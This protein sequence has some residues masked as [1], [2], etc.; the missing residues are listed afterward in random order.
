MTDL[1]NAVALHQRGQLNEAERIYRDILGADPNHLM[2]PIFLA[3]FFFFNVAKPL[4]G[5]S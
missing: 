4:R 5:S 2:R 3:L 1:Q